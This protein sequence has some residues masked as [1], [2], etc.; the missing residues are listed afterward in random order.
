MSCEF[1]FDLICRCRLLLRVIASRPV[2]GESV[3][4]RAGRPMLITVQCKNALIIASIN[5]LLV[6]DT[7]RPARHLNPDLTLTLTFRDFFR[8]FHLTPFRFSP[9]RDSA[10]KS[11]REYV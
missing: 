10:I 6:T 3:P 1:R 5:R 8:T 7:A 9:F 4:T 2:C 11:F